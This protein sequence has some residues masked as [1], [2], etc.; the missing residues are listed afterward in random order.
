MLLGWTLSRL[1]EWTLPTQRNL[2][3]GRFQINEVA[4]QPH[5]VVGDEDAVGVTIMQRSGQVGIGVTLV[6]LGS[7][8]TELAMN[9]TTDRITECRIL[10]KCWGTLDHLTASNAHCY[11]SNSPPTTLHLLGRSDAKVWRDSSYHSVIRS[12][13][14][15][16]QCCQDGRDYCNKYPCVRKE[17]LLIRIAAR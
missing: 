6:R 2:L 17:M 3:P 13:H 5:T 10:D 12:Y 4:A 1:R 9:N 15:A 14:S 8:I 11:M 16:T 7:A